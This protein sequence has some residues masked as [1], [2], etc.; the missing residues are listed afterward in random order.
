MPSASATTVDVS[1]ELSKGGGSGILWVTSNQS[2]KSDRDGNDIPHALYDFHALRHYAASAWIKQRVDLKRLTTW[3]GHSS[4]S[5]TLD[6]YGHLLTDDQG[7][8]AI[9]AAMAAELLA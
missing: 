4:V 5:L 6:V 3:L 8:A 7:D 2:G 1:Q 9:V